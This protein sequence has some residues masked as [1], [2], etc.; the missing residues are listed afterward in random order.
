MLSFNGNVCSNGD[1]D[2]EQILVFKMAIQVE[3]D[4]HDGSPGEGWVA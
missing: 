3:I 4:V 2:G 1:I